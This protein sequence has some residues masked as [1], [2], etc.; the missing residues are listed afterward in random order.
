MKKLYVCLGSACHLKGAEKIAK[1]FEEMIETHGLKD[2]I[3]LK[4]S[5]CLG[6][7]LEAVVIKFEDRIIKN[8]TPENAKEVFEK[9]ILPLLED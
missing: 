2:K 8:V 1:I 7:C 3:I 9:E 4:G 6:P 5:F